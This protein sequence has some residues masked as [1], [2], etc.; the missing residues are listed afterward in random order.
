MKNL[1]VILAVFTI[2]AGAGFINFSMAQ[3]DDDPQLLP[4]QV[5]PGPPAL[6]DPGREPQPP[7]P[8]RIPPLPPESEAMRNIPLSTLLE[9]LPLAVETA[10]KTIKLL[11]PGRAWMMSGPGGEVEIKAGLM[12]KGSV[13]AVLRFN[14]NDGNILPV[15]INPRLYDNNVRPDEIEAQLTD[16]MQKLVILPY[17]EFMEPELCWSFPVAMGNMI[18]SHMKIYYTGTHIVRDFAGNREMTL[19]GQ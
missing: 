5:M 4:D 15:G 1:F 17:G 10:Q 3:Q 19:Y 16:I 9:N 12:Y 6:P 14:P 2:L 18:V 7:G 13:V 8:G 11:T